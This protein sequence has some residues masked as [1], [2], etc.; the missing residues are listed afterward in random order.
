LVTVSP[1]TKK[2]LVAVVVIFLAFFVITQPTQ[3]AAIVR[4]LLGMLQDGA[5]ALATFLRSLF[6]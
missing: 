5:E 3:S 1:G 6:A 4:D 2:F